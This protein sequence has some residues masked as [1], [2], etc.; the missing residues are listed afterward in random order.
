MFGSDMFNTMFPVQPVVDLE[1][2]M[3]SMERKQ[4][5]VEKMATK[6]NG[7]NDEN[8]KKLFGFNYNW[9]LGPLLSFKYRMHPSAK[10]TWLLGIF[11]WE[12]GS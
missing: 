4:Q 11:G 3:S 5:S 9:W 2:Y 8:A 1:N 6:L 10:V 7:V 12:N